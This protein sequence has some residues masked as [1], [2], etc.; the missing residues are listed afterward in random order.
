MTTTQRTRPRTLATNVAA[1]I[2]PE[3]AEAA[4]AEAN[5]SQEIPGDLFAQALWILATH[6]ECSKVR[7]IAL[8]ELI[9]FPE[10]VNFCLSG[11]LSPVYRQ[12][13]AATELAK[14]LSSCSEIQQMA[15]SMIEIEECKPLGI[16]LLRHWLANPKSESILPAI[17]ARL[18]VASDE[19]TECLIEVLRPYWTTPPVQGK[20]LEIAD[21]EGKFT[22]RQATAA[23]R[24]LNYKPALDGVLQHCK[25]CDCQYP[26]ESRQRHG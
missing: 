15:F 11:G 1:A 13:K 16:E 10:H 26:E 18:D 19:M 6:A 20:L 9:R 7:E 4:I 23:R 12:R 17:V 24:A 25:E 2:T 8:Q 22:L 3:Q 21:A 14:G 5:L